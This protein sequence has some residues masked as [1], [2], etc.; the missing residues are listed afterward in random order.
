M[1]FLSLFDF[2]K[3][4]SL[5]IHVPFCTKKCDYCAF[6]SCPGKSA[7]DVEKYVSRAVN[8]IKA[9]VDR[10]DKPFYTAFIGGGNPGCLTVEQMER[11]CSAVCKKG[12]PEEFTTEMNPESL[13]KQ[14]F[15]LFED[16]LTRLSIGVQSFD[17]KALKFLGRN[18]TLS[19]TIDGIEKACE[20]RRQK[21]ILLSFDLITCLGKWHDALSD[22]KTAVEKYK[23]DHLSLYAL[24]LEEGT[25]LY[26]KKI[27]IPNSDEQFDILTELWKYLEQ[28]SYTHYEVSNFALNGKISLHNS[29]YWD[30]CQYVGLGPGSA[31][32]G[33][34]D[35]LANR[36]DFD[37]NVE[38]YVNGK[39]FEGF[40]FEKLNKE[41]TLEEFVMMG[42]RHSKG[43]SLTRLKNDFNC[44]LDIVPKGYCVK[45]QYLVPDDCGLMTSDAASLEILGRLS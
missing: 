30:Y 3:Q 16:Y 20:L 32:T 34:A 6:Y 7:E 13:T 11:I 28:N 38:S 24:T 9:V 26:K 41:E 25:V 19:Q 17:E 29:V 45:N 8:E 39:L 35:T 10:M 23:P 21:G 31:S 4:T 36:V 27:H 37:R 42:L 18:A 22:V 1:D 33:F 2:S 44:S 12:R 15:Y 43:L 40:C 14:H 5:Y